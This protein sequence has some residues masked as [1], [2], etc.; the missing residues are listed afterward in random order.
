MKGFKYAGIII[1]LVLLISASCSVLSG[2]SYLK[3]SW[4]GLPLFFYDNNPSTPSIVHNDQ[5]FETN[6]GSYYMEYIAWDGSAWYMYY[7]IEVDSGN[8]LDAGDYYWYYTYLFSTGPTFNRS[9]E[10][11]NIIKENTYN[12]SKDI[13]SIKNEAKPSGLNR[14]P[15]T[16]RDI[17]EFK[18]GRMKTEYGNL[19]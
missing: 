11:K 8:A 17:L 5:Y 12:I 3:Y 13:N 9:I 16:G 6:A 4:A 19:Y 18:N 10:V 2:K 7:K 1:V 15:V 14:G